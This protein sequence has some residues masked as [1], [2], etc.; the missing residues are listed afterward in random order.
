M[1]ELETVRV[2]LLK[3]PPPSLLLL[4]PKA[5]LPEMVELE[6][7]T[8]PRLLK[9]PPLPDVFA[10]DTVT[11]EMERLPSVLILKI[12]KLRL[13][14]PLSPLIVRLEE[15]GPVM[16]R[17]PAVDVATIEG[18]DELRVMVPV[19]PE[20]RMSSLVDAVFASIMAC[21]REPGPTSLVFVTMKV[22]GA[23]RSSRVISSSLEEMG[24]FLA[25]LLGEILKNLRKT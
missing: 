19:T 13:A 11:P 24:D 9:A 3:I 7:E 23:I 16:V 25:F 12:L 14:T 15:P 2:P 18:N 5:E 21:L 10:P 1:V 8:V 17:V 20:K 6:T 22:A 4:G